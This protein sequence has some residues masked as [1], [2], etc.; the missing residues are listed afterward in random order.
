MTKENVMNNAF[1]LVVRE[2][3]RALDQEYSIRMLIK[4]FPKNKKRISSLSYKYDKSIKE[5]RK[6]HQT[7]TQI[8]KQYYDYLMSKFEFEFTDYLPQTRRYRI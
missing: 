5:Y 4:T 3:E 1:E 6:E 2:Y 8:I 7:I